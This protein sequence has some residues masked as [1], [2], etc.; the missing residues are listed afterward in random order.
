MFLTFL[1]HQP[2]Q[3]TDKLRRREKIN[4]IEDAS[5]MWCFIFNYIFEQGANDVARIGVLMS[6]MMKDARGGTQG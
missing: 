1:K 6:L 2:A 3:F 5:E 4:F